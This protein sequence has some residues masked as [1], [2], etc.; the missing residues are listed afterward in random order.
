IEKRYQRSDEAWVWVDLTVSL[1]RNASTSPAYFI[2]GIQNIGD[3]KRAEEALQK[4]ETNF[5]QIAE[6]IQEDVWSVD[7]AI[8]K[9][10]YVSPAYE[11]VWGRTCDSVYK[12]PKSFLDAIHP[13]DLQRVLVAVGELEDGLPFDQEYRIVRPDGTIRWVWDRGAPV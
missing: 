3:R 2:A 11:R 4:S 1:V 10:V 9:M 7:P 8:N 6:T 5:R 13:D 12:D